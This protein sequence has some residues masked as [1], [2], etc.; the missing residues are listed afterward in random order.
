MAFLQ[1][2]LLDGNLWQRWSKN[3][4]WMFPGSF[5]VHLIYHMKALISHSMSRSDLLLFPLWM[6]FVL[7]LGFHFNTAEATVLRLR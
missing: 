2:W 5:L 1:R 6:S 4:V 7:G 3:M